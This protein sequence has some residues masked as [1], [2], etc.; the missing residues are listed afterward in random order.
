M[1]LQLKFGLIISII[2]LLSFASYSNA[3]TKVVT[4]I[5]PLHSLV[6]YV[7]DGVGTPDILVDGS[8]SPQGTGVLPLYSQG[9]VA[10]LNT[11]IF[12]VQDSSRGVLAG[13][14]LELYSTQ[15][16]LIRLM[17]RYSGLR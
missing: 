10:F 6:S 4:S 3:E 7:M 12:L 11:T 17:R 13:V 2:S 15:K 9:T 16:L 14:W 1:K 5:K 8:S